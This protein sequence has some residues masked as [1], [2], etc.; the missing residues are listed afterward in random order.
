MNC[1]GQSKRNLKSENYP[2]AVT[3]RPTTL[4]LFTTMNGKIDIRHYVDNEELNS[5][6]VRTLA[7]FCDC[8]MRS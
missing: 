1:D 7:I 5:L 8:E 6:S 4:S 2:R 3:E